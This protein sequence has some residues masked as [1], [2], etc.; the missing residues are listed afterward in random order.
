M[1]KDATPS[2]RNVGDEK[3]FDSSSVSNDEVTAPVTPENGE[4]EMVYP[5]GLPF[6]LI[7]IALCLAVFVLAIDNTIIATAI[8]KITDRFN[9]LDDV[10]W[11]ASSYMLTTGC[12]QLL[13]GRLYSTFSTKW[14]FIT[15]ISIFEFGSLICGVTP[16]SIG[17]IVGMYIL[18]SAW[19]GIYSCCHC[20]EHS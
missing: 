1:A 6:W 12:F 20:Q 5:T 19:L 9:S 11:Y 2:L 16:S 18:R 14:V 13:F 8:P 3:V 4:S 17:L 15:A 10:A 7:T